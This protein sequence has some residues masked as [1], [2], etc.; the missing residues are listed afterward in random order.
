[1]ANPRFADVPFGPADPMFYLKQAADSD[2]SPE[3]IDVGIGVYRA[4]SAG[5][6]EF[7][8]VKEV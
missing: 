4:T 3:K 1:M 2:T 8:A 5:Y 6:H 7:G